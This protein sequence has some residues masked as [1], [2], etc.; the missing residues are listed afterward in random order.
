LIGKKLINKKKASIEINI[1]KN[2]HFNPTKSQRQIDDK[3][4]NRYNCKRKD[5]F[6]SSIQSSFL[7]LIASA[8]RLYTCLSEKSLRDAHVQTRSNKKKEKWLN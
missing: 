8:S 4:L 6:L 1:L 3:Q 5:L 2:P 7:L